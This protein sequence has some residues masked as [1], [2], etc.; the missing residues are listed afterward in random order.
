M[1]C[2]LLKMIKMTKLPVF[3]VIS[4]HKKPT[5]N[6]KKVRTCITNVLPTQEIPLKRETLESYWGGKI[7]SFRA[8]LEKNT[9]EDAFKKLIK[10]LEGL[11]PN[12]VSERFDSKDQEFYIRIDKQLAFLGRF[13]LSRGGNV[14]HFQF[15]FPGYLK[16]TPKKLKE[17]INAIREKK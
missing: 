17:I 10:D 2:P 13:K 1:V 16:L 11:Y 8:R 9:A 6:E 4:I 5:E 14:V 3:A 7:V 15:S 12:W